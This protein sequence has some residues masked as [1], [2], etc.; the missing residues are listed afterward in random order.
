MKT[1]LAILGCFVADTSAQYAYANPGY[2]SYY[3]GYNGYNGYNTGYLNNGYNGYNTGYGGYGYAAPVS[4]PL[5]AP[6]AAPLPV[7]APAAYPY[8]YGG[9]GG[10]STGYCDIG[11]YLRRYGGYGGSYAA[12]RPVAYNGG[13]GSAYTYVDAWG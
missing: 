13:V 2:G 4:A 12:Q 8:S 10:Y 5:P 6:V 1:V 7:A 9:C 3:G 11:D